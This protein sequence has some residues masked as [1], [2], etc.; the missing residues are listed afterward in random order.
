[1][2]YEDALQWIIDHVPTE[3]FNT[4]DKWYNKAYDRIATPRLF[5][6]VEFNKMLEDYWLGQYGRF[7]LTEDKFSATPEPLET[8]ESRARELNIPIPEEKPKPVPVIIPQTGRA[9]ELPRPILVFP[10]DTPE[11]KKKSILDRVKGF[12]RRKK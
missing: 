7:D 11:V 5:E 4:Y 12:F 1:M 10:K 3:N 2:T 9:P 8:P 6:K